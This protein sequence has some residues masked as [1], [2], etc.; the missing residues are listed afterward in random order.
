MCC[1]SLDE[2]F[3]LLHSFEDYYRSVKFII[4]EFSSIAG[5]TFRG[6]IFSFKSLPQQSS[7]ENR[8][9]KFFERVSFTS[10]YCFP[11]FLCRQVAQ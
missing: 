4:V 1:N 5:H 8:L 6:C 3:F 11:V 2:D 9:L 10:S 7:K